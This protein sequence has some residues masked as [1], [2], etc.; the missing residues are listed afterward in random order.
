MTLDQRTEILDRENKFLLALDDWIWCSK[1]SKAE[2]EKFFTV[3]QSKGWKVVF[4]LNE[5]EKI[6]PAQN[7]LKMKNGHVQ[8][9]STDL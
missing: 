3:N 9:T 1:A 2:V 6:L 7:F 5:E 4:W 8:G